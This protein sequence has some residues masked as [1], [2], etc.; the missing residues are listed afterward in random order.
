M[1]FTKSRFFVLFNFWSPSSA[2]PPVILSLSNGGVAVAGLVRKMTPATGLK[3]GDRVAAMDHIGIQYAK[4]VNTVDDKGKVEVTY[5]SSTSGKVMTKKIKA[6]KVFS[7]ATSAS[8]DGA[9]PLVHFQGER[10]PASGLAVGTDGEDT[11]VMTRGGKA[12][13]R[14]PTSSVEVVPVSKKFKRGK[15]IMAVVG[16][17]M[18]A[19][20]PRKAKIKEVIGDGLGYVVDGEKCKSV[21]L[22]GN[23]V[24]KP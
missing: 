2:T 21:K 3:A 6:E 20:I 13:L 15:T 14:L 5:M 9:P 1:H 10:G 8:A 19:R 4:V 17:G 7:W 22:Q 23:A 16:C 12:L 24:W 11:I 18:T